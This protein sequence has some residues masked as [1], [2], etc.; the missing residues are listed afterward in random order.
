MPSQTGNRPSASRPYMATGQNDDIE[1][2]T[3]TGRPL[4]AASR[5]SPRAFSPRSA[6]FQPLSF[7]R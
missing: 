2:A 4:A 3:A 5:A 1:P 7:T 6:T